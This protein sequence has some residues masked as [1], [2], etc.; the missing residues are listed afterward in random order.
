MSHSTL[1]RLR[2]VLDVRN[3]HFFNCRLG[4]SSGQGCSCWQPPPSRSDTAT[5]AWR[6]LCDRCKKSAT[7]HH[8]QL[9]GVGDG[10]PSDLVF[11]AYILVRAARLAGASSQ[12]SSSTWLRAILQALDVARRSLVARGGRAEV[13]L[14]ADLAPLQALLDKEAACLPK[15][16]AP[17]PDQ[18]V[19]LVCALDTAYFK[20]YSGYVSAF[21]RASAA[22][23]GLCSPAEYFEELETH[24]PDAHLIASAYLAS[25]LLKGTRAGRDAQGWLQE[26]SAESQLARQGKAS[27][28]LLRVWATRWREATR[29]L[30][31]AGLDAGKA[32]ALMKA[33]SARSRAGQPAR[34]ASGEQFG[35][36]P[37]PVCWKLLEEWRDNAR[38]WCCHLYAYATPC[39]AALEAIA[40]CAPIVE[41]GAGTGYWAHLL[42]ARH[43]SARLLAF[44]V[45]PT[46]HH[47]YDGGAGARDAQPKPKRKTKRGGRGQGGAPSM[48]EYHGNLP[49]WF[50]VRPGGAS[51]LQRG[52]ADPK[53]ALLLCYPPPDSGMAVEALKNF[54]GSRLLHIGEW[55]GDTGTAAFEQQLNRQFCQTYLQRART[56][57]GGAWTCEGRKELEAWRNVLPETLGHAPLSSHGAVGEATYVERVMMLDMHVYEQ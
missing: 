31:A 41:L 11:Q 7:E 15:A 34:Q 2:S 27:N 51:A 56:A 8:L 18:A 21:G 30:S 39:A 28:E 19:R 20:I 55:Q 42:K 1:V 29:L 50:Q 26:A 54:T 36:T 46:P 23:R 14:G 5:P 57:K 10:S 52:G 44:D 24:S 43:P 25:P 17:P 6:E 9:Q 40:G 37:P 38:D 32:A 48:N 47:T 16:G 13:G 35:Q 4:A 53:E 33:R 3:Q 45:T 22:Q 12:L 49:A